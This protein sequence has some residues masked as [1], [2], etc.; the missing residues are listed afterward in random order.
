MD[1]QINCSL[2]GKLFSKR[3]AEYNRQIRN[4]N[5][6]FY[7]SAECF[8]TIITVKKRTYKIYNKPCLKCGKLFSSSDAKKARKCCSLECAVYY[9]QTF[10]PRKPDHLKVKNTKSYH[11]YSNREFICV[12]CNNPFLKRVWSGSIRKTCSKECKSILFSKIL[13]A[14]P[15]CGG[16]TNYKKYL[17]KDI[18]MD[19][20]WEVE[21]A[22]LLDKKEIKWKRDR[23]IN[24]K[25]IDKEGKERRY[26]PDFYLPDFDVYLDPKNKFL[27]EKDCFKIEYVIKHH[28]VKIIWGLLP[29]I[30]NFVNELNVPIAQLERALD[31]ESRG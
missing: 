15:N 24:F 11:K 18:W 22:T 25:W 8:K 31:Y 20:K 10:R 6:N 16:Q 28:K 7:C 2:C 29:K 4:G 12:V 9:A 23:S 21:V 17:Y 13:R 19:S 30:I 3:K 27:I 5:N 14:H 26:Y 1:I